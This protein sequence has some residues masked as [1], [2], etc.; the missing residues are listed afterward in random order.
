MVKL[1]KLKLALILVILLVSQPF[2]V[3]LT[4]NSDG[5]AEIHLKTAASEG[6]NELTLPV[7]PIPE[8]IEISVN[9]RSLIPLYENDT[10]YFFSP[11]SGTAEIS[12]LANVTLTG[13]LFKIWITG[14]QLVKLILAPEIVLLSIPNKVENFTYLDDKLVIFFEGPDEI[15]YSI[16]EK[17]AETTAIQPFTVTSATSRSFTAK[18][19]EVT[20][21]TSIQP[22]KT[23][24]AR[25]AGEKTSERDYGLIAFIAGV[26]GAI[27]IFAAI[28]YR[29]RKSGAGRVEVSGLTDVDLSIIE[30]MKS[31]GGSVLQGR[32]QAR[33]GLPKTTL[34]RHVKKLEKMGYIKIIK[35]GSFNR[36]ILLKEV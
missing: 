17:A 30:V 9:G 34:W 5:I 28:F 3:T 18:P 27:A 26:L 22:T 6:L 31:E 2:A 15:D 7:E 32:L 19:P 10:L 11:T 24:E 23:S 33:L 4:I 1:E 8:T 29:G 21:A 14:S 12:Y 35:E 20:T 13:K 36:L 25:G 16:K